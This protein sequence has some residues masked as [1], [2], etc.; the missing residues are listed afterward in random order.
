MLAPK[1]SDSDKKSKNFFQQNE[2]P[3]IMNKVKEWGNFF[4]SCV[5]DFIETNF[6]L[7]NPTNSIDNISSNFSIG[8][9]QDELVDYND[10]SSFKADDINDSKVTDHYCYESNRNISIDSNFSG[11]EE[12]VKSN[13]SNIMAPKGRISKKKQGSIQSEKVGKFHNSYFYSNEETDHGNT[14]FFDTYGNS[15]LVMADLNRAGNCLNPDYSIEPIEYDIDFLG[16]SNTQGDKSEYFTGVITK[17]YNRSETTPLSGNNTKNT[18]KNT[19]N[20]ADPENT[21]TVS[22]SDDE[23][24][25][26][27]N[28]SRIMPLRQKKQRV[29]YRQLHN[30]GITVTSSSTLTPRAKKNRN[31]PLKT[32]NAKDGRNGKS[33]TS[34]EGQSSKNQA[35]AHLELDVSSSPEMEMAE[36]GNNRNSITG[37]NIEQGSFFEDTYFP[38]S[39]F[40]GKQ[41]SSGLKIRKDIVTKYHLNCDY[42]PDNTC[43]RCQETFNRLRNSD[44]IKVRNC[45]NCDNN[46]CLGCEGERPKLRDDLPPRDDMGLYFLN[47]QQFLPSFQVNITGTST[48][49][50]SVS[51]SDTIVTIPPNTTYTNTT[52]SVATGANATPVNTYV[53]LNRQVNMILEIGVQ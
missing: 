19:E 41:N 32:T 36:D 31:T 21:V 49:Q 37:L 28:D 3:P 42:C 44:H 43:I 33:S 22:S 8:M 24:I 50:P 47:D 12:S 1:G 7:P 14:D 11:S 25:P 34:T 23:P 15:G 9:G 27:S 35:D 16:H 39:N 6:E 40:S 46:I 52:N 38:E 10:E 13:S 26:N 18:N 29:D 20:F 53:N 4:L 48:S 2:H 45:K 5:S 30:K 17:D 51:F